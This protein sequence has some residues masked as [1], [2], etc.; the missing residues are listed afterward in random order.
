MSLYDKKIVND[1]GVMAIWEQTEMESELEALLP[2]A[3]TIVAGIK[4]EKRRKERLTVQLLL[5]EIFGSGVFLDHYPNGQPFLHKKSDC[6]DTA[7]AHDCMDTA[8]VHVS[9]A[10]THRFVVV[11]THPQMRVGVDIE[12]L[13]RNFSAVA[14]RAL[15][16]RER[17]Y[18]C[19]ASPFPAEASPFPA[20]AHHLQVDMRTAQLAILWCAKEALYKCISQ[21]GVDFARQMEIEPFTPQKFGT[22]FARF[23]HKIQGNGMKTAI[24]THLLNYEIIENHVLVYIFAE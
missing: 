9:I 14:Q 4:S 13:D 11:L 2:N 5:K 20:A 3:P 18:L 21:E 6:M 16:D 8:R 19:E 15:S 23:F 12:S 22:L 24:S 1:V 17:S 10:H 7:R